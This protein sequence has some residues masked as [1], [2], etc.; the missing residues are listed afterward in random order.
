MKNFF[1]LLM[2]PIIIGIC[3]PATNA[4]QTQ[5]PGGRSTA[6]PATAPANSGALHLAQSA[7]KVPYGVL[8]KEGIKADLDRL[9]RFVDEN[10]PAQLVDRQ[11]GVEVADYA[12]ITPGTAL[13][14]GRFGLTG[15]EWGV[16]YSGM[17]RVAQVTGDKQYSGYVYR[18]FKM[19]GNAYPYFKKIYEQTGTTTLRQPINPQALDDA[20]SVCAAMIKAVM[21]DPSL[22]ETLRPLIDNYFNFVM[23]K[24]Y[25]LGDGILA[26]RRPHLNSVW[27]DDMYMGIPA[28]AYMGQLS[29]NQ[30]GNL[31]AKCFDEAALQIQ[32]FKK[33]MW[34]PEKNLFRH[35]WVEAMAYHPSFFWGRAN[36]WAVLT[37][38][39]VLDVLPQN[40]KARPEILELLQSHIVGLAALQSGDGFWH[41]LLDRND[42]YL[43][44][45]ATAIFTYCIAHAINRGWVDAMAFGPVAQLGWEAVSTMINDQGQVEGTCVGTGMGFDPA[46]YYYRLVSVNAAHGYG[47]VLLAG[48]EM[49]ELIGNR[50]PKIN[51]TAIQYYNTDPGKNTAIFSID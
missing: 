25:R 38:C 12:K 41:Q 26:R 43:E 10:T 24:E 19:L 21:A 31:A 7:Y 46:Y 32:L 9:F 34:I 3:V 42:S 44:T 47:P 16:T 2:T 36:G 23:N 6:Q 30:Q 40:H 49:I 1:R 15:Y 37:L 35:G 4:Q 5:A 13:A 8:T 39:D 51:D 33:R 28:I 14:R 48:A 27:L 45:S 50:Y 11:T 17:L 22:T 29:R 18:R 20:G